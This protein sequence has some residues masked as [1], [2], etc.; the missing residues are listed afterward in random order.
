M[1]KTVK[2]VSLVLVMV[3]AVAL[4]AACGPASNPDKAAEALKE[5]GY[6]VVNLNGAEVAKKNDAEGLVAMVT[7]LKITNLLK[8]EGE[9]IVIFYFDSSKTASDYWNSDDMEDA[10]KEIQSSFKDAEMVFEKSGKM[11]YI[12]TKQAVKDAK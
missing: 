9:C 7:G 10:K 6:E 1:K 11:I 5:N 12:G 3:L 8:G 4:I 2:V